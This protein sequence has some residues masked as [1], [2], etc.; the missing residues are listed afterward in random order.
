MCR[1]RTFSSSV[2][3][4]VA[5]ALTSLAFSFPTAAHTQPTIP[6]D[7]PAA[8]Q[9]SGTN[10]LNAEKR[11]DKQN[12]CA[13]AIN[14]ADT[15]ACIAREYGLTQENYAAYVHSISALLRLKFKDDTGGTVLDVARGFETAEALWLRVRDLQCAAAGDQVPGDHPAADQQC[16]L[17]L[18]R[19]HIYDLQALYPDLWTK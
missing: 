6:A 18:T 4:G 10:A 14:Q 13:N 5:G 2:A 17:Y 8:L 1:D 11:R 15:L 7:S 12:P 16:R 9:H 3:L 19:R